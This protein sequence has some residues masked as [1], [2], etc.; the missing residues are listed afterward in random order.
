MAEMER[1]DGIDVAPVPSGRSWD[2]AG[3]ERLSTSAV[4]GKVLAAMGDEDPD[5]VVL[6]ADLKF[7]NQTVDFERAHPER[8]VNV[9]ISEQHMV[10]MAAGMASASTSAA[11]WPS[12]VPGVSG[13]GTGVA[14][15][16]R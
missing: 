6:T 5:I 13:A 8:F 3:M 4:A 1:V 10:S 12:R 11:T 2:L 14:C 16:S 7:S 9:G 15:G